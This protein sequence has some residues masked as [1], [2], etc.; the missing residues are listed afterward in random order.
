MSNELDVSKKNE[1][2][3]SQDRMGFESEIT[4]DDLI[5]PRAKLFQGLPIETEQFPEGKG[6]QILNN[7]TAEQ[8]PDEFI[9]VFVTIEWMKFNPR[10]SKDEGFDP[11]HEPGAL[12]WKTADKN[13]PEVANDPESWRYKCL[14]FL[15]Y[16]PGVS[17]PLVLTFSKTSFAAGKKLLSLAQFSGGNMF[18]RKYRLTSKKEEK[19]GNIYYVMQVAPA[20]VASAEEQQIALDWYKS[21]RGKTLKAHDDVTTC[22]GDTKTAEWSE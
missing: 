19:E 9:P 21:F 10:N 17:M 6:G 8:L 7:L 14:V 18:S 12:I 4:T 13:A 2:A 16:F 3:V 5:L 20:G 11:T 22:A 1:I 15:T